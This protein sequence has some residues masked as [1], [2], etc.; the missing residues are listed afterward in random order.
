MLKEFYL[1][2]AFIFLLSIAVFLF[3]EGPLIS[4]YKHYTGLRQRSEIGKPD[5]S[6]EVVKV[7]KPELKNN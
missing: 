7:M 3:M 2:H 4:L 6:N 5:E 1:S